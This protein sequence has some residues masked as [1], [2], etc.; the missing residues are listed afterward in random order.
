MLLK[1]KKDEQDTSFSGKAIILLMK[2]LHIIKLSHLV[3][4][5]FVL[6]VYEIANSELN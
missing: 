6:D 2:Q 3:I 5:S 1:N 4:Y